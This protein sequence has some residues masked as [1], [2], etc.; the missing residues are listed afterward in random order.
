MF[1][2]TLSTV[3]R[4]SESSTR[5]AARIMSSLPSSSRASSS[6][7]LADLRPA[8]GSTQPN[9][10]LG[11]GNSS[12]KGGQAGR[13][14]K[15]QKARHGNG[16]PVP[17]FEGGQTPL[18]RLFPKRGFTPFTARTYVALPLHRLQA[19]LAAG[20]LDPSAPV[21]IGAVVRANLIHGLSGK[22]GV[23][24]LGPADPDLPL[25]PL[26][27]EL[28]RFSK[29]AADAVIEAGGKVTAVYHNN[30]SL[31]QEVWPEKFVG[32]EVRQAKPI[33]RTDIEYY[34]N[35]EKH[36]YLAAQAAP[37]VAEAAQ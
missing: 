8:P 6:V 11:R 20:R 22:A 5:C 32:R 37:A 18:T 31:R 7:S 4:L 21:T 24:L 3:L 36:G 17:G 28:S 25:P 1:G 35:P 10:R 15:G 14:H 29:S 13:G 30:L 19:W 2:A 33:R 23:K 16:K 9:V 26:T 34:Q 12:T 27:L